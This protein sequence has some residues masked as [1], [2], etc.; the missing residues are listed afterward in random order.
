MLMLYLEM[1]KDEEDKSKFEFLYVKYKNLMWYIANKILHDDDLSEDAVHNSFL[2][3]IN[4][5]DNIEDIS[6]HKTKGFM[7]IVVENTAKNM[8]NKRKLSS[9]ISFDDIETEI[10][11]TFDLDVQINKNITKEIVKEKIGLL[12]SIYK[13]VLILKYINDCS[14][15]SIADILNIN[16]TTVRKRIERAKQK[17]YI[18]LKEEDL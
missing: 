18:Y 11:D 17:I 12:P 5:L 4:H 6:C 9:E 13:D 7:V 15:K 10:P 14:D 2:K 16:Q 1:L 8:Y 3:V